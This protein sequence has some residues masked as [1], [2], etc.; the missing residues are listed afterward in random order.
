MSSEAADKAGKVAR[1]IE[2][3]TTRYADE[4][5]TLASRVFAQQFGP[6]IPSLRKP[7]HGARVPQRPL[8]NTLALPG[9]RYETAGG[10]T[11]MAMAWKSSGAPDM[12][13]HWTVNVPVSNGLKNPP[14]RSA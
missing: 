10:Y 13:F 4:H 5:F 11:E 7:G 9:D 12:V 6:R 14:S 1:A 2:E 3:R 8:G